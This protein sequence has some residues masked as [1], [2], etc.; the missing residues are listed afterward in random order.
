MHRIKYPRLTI[1]ACPTIAMALAVQACG[2]PEPGELTELTESTEVSHEARSFN[3]VMIRS[4]N[5]DKTEG[6]R[7]YPR[8]MQRI[9]EM[10]RAG[11]PSVGLIG[12][13]EVRAEMTGCR[14][15][16]QRG[17]RVN[18]ARCFAQLLTDRYPGRVRSVFYQTDY[19]FWPD[20]DGGGGVA[21]GPE[22]RLLSR[23][24][25]NI[26]PGL[27]CRGWSCQNYDRYLI[28]AR[29]QH[30]STGKILRFYNTHFYP[31]R[32]GFRKG[33]R[34]T[35]A[36]ELVDRIR[37]RVRTGELPPIV[38]G[39]FN[40]RTS[41]ASYGTMEDNFWR[42]EQVIQDSCGH[43]HMSI[44]RIYV[45]KKS[46]FPQTRGGFQVGPQQTLLTTQSRVSGVPASDHNASGHVLYINPDDDGRNPRIG[47]WAC[48]RF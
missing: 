2:P 30:R 4:V 20:P 45:G 43:A 33:V 9:S 34:A 18:G 8:R 29:L 41:E 19:P 25:F 38:V 39:D 32:S 27:E 46:A 5:L 1:L 16:G 37:S 42:P 21:Y 47:P 31:G 36:R 22:W 48:Y 28:E 7:Y 26:G 13:Q 3:P 14:G 15:R 23:A 6:R 40:N 11:W 44:D 12:L 17:R 10:V 24:R 35:Q